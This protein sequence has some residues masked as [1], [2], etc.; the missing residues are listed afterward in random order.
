MS[1]QSNSNQILTNSP[2]SKG[3]QM[4]SVDQPAFQIS[5]SQKEES[6][7]QFTTGFH[8]ESK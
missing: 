4:A 7:I 3:I 8:P 2:D 5:K 6:A 1:G